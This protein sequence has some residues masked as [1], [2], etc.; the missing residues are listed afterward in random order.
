MP[1]RALLALLCL[2]A[3]VAGRVLFRAD[4]ET[5]DLSQWTQTGTRGQNATPRNVQVVSD[6]V[7]R[8]KYAVRMTI[9]PDDVFNDRQLRVQ[10]GGPRVTVEEGSDT[11]LAFSLS[12]PQAPQDRDNFFYWEGNPPPRYNNVMTWWVEPGEN[13]KALIKYGTGNLG[14]NG[15][16]WQAE[17]T[18]GQWHRLAMHIRW[19]EDPAQGRTRLWFDGQLVLD[20]ALKT[21][22]PEAVYFCQPGI[23]RSPHRPSVDTIYFDDFILADTLAEI[24]AAP[25][26]FALAGDWAF[27]VSLPG[28]PAATL[29]VAPPVIR[30][31]TAERYDALPVYNPQA[32]GWARGARL[33]GLRSQETTSPYLLDPASFALRAGAASD[34]P[35]FR[36]GMDYELD[37]VWGTFGRLTGG[38]IAADQPVYATY[39]HAEQ[40][41]DAVVLAADGRLALR[42]GPPRAAAPAAA[43]LAAGDRLL[44]HVFVPRAIERLTADHLF[45]ILETAYPEPP[46]P[47]ERHPVMERLVGRLEAGEP[48]RILAWGDSVTDAGYLP[49]GAT[50][51]WQEQF[52]ARLRQRFPRARIELMTE[53]WGGRNTSSYLAEPP[54]SAH[55]YQEKVLG[56]KP[57]LIISEFVNDSSLTPARV[58]ER[59]SKLLADFTAIGA[60]WI[61]LTPHYVQP[62]RM[63]F[64]REREIDD[65]P[66]PYVAGLRQFAARHGVPLAD[67]SLRYG[68]LWRQGIPYSTLLLNAINHPDAHGMR[69]FA[70]AIMALFR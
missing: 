66:R 21:K 57:D 58:E 37:P 61:I 67:A 8:G 50:E 27:Q 44:G 5:G 35:L 69:L 55:N 43:P 17:F 26:T 53:A 54:G 59:Y 49:G 22:G 56:R 15:T 9:H 23:H 14:R 63:D 45:P 18:P 65:D 6:I 47:G 41:L 28:G 40:R 2:A 32:G 30:A 20:Q 70:E 12:M 29:A 60:A 10:L 3:P 48:L 1:L 19:S 34:A 33:A 11:Y 16:H 4:F 7:H 68:R 42:P 62:Q 25:A 46:P 51:R 24:E 13:G 39:R 52:V 64:R 36:P 31:V 38:R